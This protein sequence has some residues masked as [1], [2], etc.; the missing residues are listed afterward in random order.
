ME[1]S[2]GM[3]VCHLY[4]SLRSERVGFQAILELMEG[5]EV[6]IGSSVADLSVPYTSRSIRTR[7]PYPKGVQNGLD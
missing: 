4:G 7:L 3:E 2:R 1:V 6:S 5:M